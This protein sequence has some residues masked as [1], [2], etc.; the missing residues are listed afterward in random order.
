[1][2][3]HNTIRFRNEPIGSCS[4]LNP[5]SN[6]IAKE[7]LRRRVF[8]DSQ[9]YDP[10]TQLMTCFIETFLIIAIAYMLTIILLLLSDLITLP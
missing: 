4:G 3:Y 1:M 8:N 10:D 5:I 2:L 9:K 6:E 7:E